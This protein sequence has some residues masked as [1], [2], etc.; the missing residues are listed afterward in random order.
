MTDIRALL[1]CPFCGS[2]NVTY[3]KRSDF[4]MCNDCGAMCASEDTL[5]ESAPVDA[6]NRRAALAAASVP[7]T[8]QEPAEWQY[9]RWY[10]EAREWGNWKKVEP[11][12][13][14]FTVM[15]RVEELRAYIERGEKIELRALYAASQNPAQVSGNVASHAAAQMIDNAGCASSVSGNGDGGA[16]VSAFPA[17]GRPID[18]I[19]PEAAAR[20]AAAPVVAAPAPAAQPPDAGMA[21][22]RESMARGIA[23]KLCEN[24]GCDPET[25]VWQ[26][27]AGPE[28]WGDVWMKYLPDAQELLE[29]GIAAAAASDARARE[30]DATLPAPPAQPEQTNG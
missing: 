28:P 16:A 26:G 22:D 8:E 7:E 10:S 21:Y 17:L 3:S 2:G 9:R 1:A 25:L 13:R 15:D 5:P 27:G 30:Y 11:L 23:V 24:D 20:A 12:Q 6:W 18:E 14:N 19:F 29:A 4:V